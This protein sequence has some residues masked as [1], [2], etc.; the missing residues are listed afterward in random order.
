M[1]TVRMLLFVVCLAVAGAVL[2]TFTLTSAYERRLYTDRLQAQQAIIEELSGEEYSAGRNLQ[3]LDEVVRYYSYYAGS[4]DAQAML[5]A[6]FKAYVAASGDPYAQYYTLEEY[7]AI[8]AENSGDY[9]GIGVTVVNHIL[10]TES[11]DYLTFWVQ[12]V[13]G[14][15]SAMEAGL[16]V[17]DHI[18]AVEQP[19]GAI[20]TLNET[21]YDQALA[22]VRGEE[23]TTVRLWVLRPLEG[24]G[25]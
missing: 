5:E 23:G 9:C 13:Y 16:Q 7:R 21:G 8:A 10:Q 12:E 2:L 6:A 25:Y 17:G 14:S 11:G 24:G 4:M 3:L 20:L 22:A 19:D 1:C 15:S 18:Y